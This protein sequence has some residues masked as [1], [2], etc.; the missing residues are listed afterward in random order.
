[1]IHVDADDP[2]PPFEQIRAGLASEIQSGRLSG[3][4]RLPTVRQLAGDLR[5]AVGTVARAYREL[6][7]AGLVTKHDFKDGR[8]RFEQ[9]PDEHHDHLIDVR[10]GKVIE[11]RNEDIEAIQELI[12][13]RLGYRL[14]DHRLELYGI[15]LDADLV[16]D[17]RCLPNPHY[18][19]RLRPLTGRDQPVI[20][21][22]AGV[23]EVS[24]MAE[25][26]RNFI[27]TWL[28]A[29]VRDNRSYLT[30]AIGCT[31]GKHRSVYL[32]EWLAAHFRGRLS[33]LVRHRTAARRASDAGGFTP[34]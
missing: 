19:P 25:D 14:V 3:G 27:D 2:T 4:R 13:K 17:V 23:P 21:F 22:L 34:Q 5:V 33:V 28:P 7:E 31:G 30:V 1:M 12:A 9:I 16:F 18:D 10:S 6:E 11:F 20:D 24:R 29:Y 32:A 8:A 15:P 26:I